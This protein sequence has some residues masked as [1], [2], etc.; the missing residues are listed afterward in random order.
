MV[1]ELQTR[2]GQEFP[3]PTELDLFDYRGARFEEVT[4]KRQFIYGLKVSILRS[5]QALD[6]FANNSLEK[7][8]RLKEIGRD[9]HNRFSALDESIIF[10]ETYLK[11]HEEL[12]KLGAKPEEVLDF[13]NFCFEVQLKAQ[14]ELG[15]SNLGFPGADI[16][17]QP[18]VKGI[19]N[20]VFDKE[21]GKISQPSWFSGNK[22]QWVDFVRQHTG[23]VSYVH[24]A[25][26]FGVRQGGPASPGGGQGGGEVDMIRIS[27]IPDWLAASNVPNKE[28]VEK[29]LAEDREQ[30]EQLREYA[31]EINRQLTALRDRHVEKSE[32]VAKWRRELIAKLPLEIRDFPTFLMYLDVAVPLTQIATE[33]LT[34]EELRLL[35]SE[36]MV[37]A[38][39]DTFN[40]YTDATLKNN[41]DI[42]TSR[43]F[44]AL[45]FDNKFKE[46]SLVRPAGLSGIVQMIKLLCGQP[47]DGFSWERLKIEDKKAYSALYHDL[48]PHFFGAKQEERDFLIEFVDQPGLTYQDLIFAVV[49]TARSENGIK[50]E[51]MPEIDQKK[52]EAMINEFYKFTKKW[53]R[54]NFKW[55]L[56]CMFESLNSG[57]YNSRIADETVTNSPILSEI[58]QETV[59]TEQETEELSRDPFFGWKLFYITN[60]RS[61]D[62]PKFH[63][64]VH[65][66]NTPE[67]W[68][69]LRSLMTK[70]GV[71]L[72]NKADSI[73]RALES[74][75]LLPD[76]VKN[77]RPRYFVNGEKYKKMKRDD[78]RIMYR[79]DPESKVIFF[80]VEPRGHKGYI[81]PQ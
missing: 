17:H 5:K 57:G 30:K 43:E 61:P 55:A 1:S 80:Y 67:R 15:K 7:V 44:I 50:L 39:F 59:Q 25:Q 72:A 38:H 49:D 58:E 51:D 34:K 73:V 65:G 12:P 4:L 24:G 35:G 2:E 6:G 20:K 77:L 53:I 42:M 63:L 19:F 76:T 60:K 56:N 31:K 22:G 3:R 68:Q 27:E 14:K 74:L 23:F 75:I 13:F 37:R 45:W 81:K 71:S 32:K 9:I 36:R 10:S 8:E 62:N 79:I 69:D 70:E 64:P 48:R 41:W 47:A 40:Y 33:G 21:I 11:I 16:V 78:A 52:Y 18:A 28:I 29:E 54:A 46:A 66:E 26:R